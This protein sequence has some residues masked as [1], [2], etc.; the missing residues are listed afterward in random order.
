MGQV[1]NDVKKEEPKNEEKK[2]GDENKNPAAVG[3][4]GAGAAEKPQDKSQKPFPEI[5]VCLLNFDN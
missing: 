2:P 3:A 4:E 5:K 1:K